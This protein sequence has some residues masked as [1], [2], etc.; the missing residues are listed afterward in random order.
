MLNGVAYVELDHCLQP[1]LSYSA[2]LLVV[3]QCSV[4]VELIIIRLVWLSSMRIGRPTWMSTSR[5]S[6][7]Y[8]QRIRGLPLHLEEG[9]LGS[10]ALVGNLEMC[11]LEIGPEATVARNIHD[12]THI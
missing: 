12:M 10:T 2:P 4:G 3:R 6:C 5:C 9:P 11:F 8:G 7:L 1:K